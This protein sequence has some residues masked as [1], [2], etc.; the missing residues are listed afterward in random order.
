MRF[1][2]LSDEQR[3]AF[4]RDGYLVVPRAIGPDTV[5]A[6]VAAGDRLV[7]SNLVTGRQRNDRGYDGFR[8]VVALDPAFEALLACEATLP[9]VLQLMSPNLQLHTSHLIY[10]QPSGDGTAARDPGWHRD[11]N[12]FPS[13]LGH[14]AAPRVEIKVAFQLSDAS[15]PGCGQ[16]VVSPGSHR[17]KEALRTNADG[18]P[19]DVAEPLLSPGDAMLFE[20]RTWH[21]GGFNLC[22]RVRKTVMFG[23]SYRWMRPDD[24]CAYP[25]ELIERCDPI[26]RQLLGDFGGM[27]T[28]DGQF[29][30]SMMRH[31]PLR[32][33]CDDH[34]IGS[35]W[36]KEPALAM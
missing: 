35:A 3:L 12:T 25:P 28:A 36:E 20:N 5:A 31:A 23:Y 21:A 7:A 11:I 26:E 15:E 17:L 4:E 9:L 24:T 16:T 2:P 14:A 13:D 22:G 34:G 32:K 30:P 29:D 19:D 27:M 6:L 8:N 18:D 10:K 1:T 33:W